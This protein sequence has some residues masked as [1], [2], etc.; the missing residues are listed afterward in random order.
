MKRPHTIIRPKPYGGSRRIPRSRPEAAAELVRVEYERDRL[1]RELAQLGARKA[2]AASTLRKL[3]LRA[4][5]LHD[6]LDSAQVAPR[7]AG[8]AAV[9]PRRRSP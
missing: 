9:F 5:L 1:E 8:K 2:A 3:E 6:A 4:K 7:L